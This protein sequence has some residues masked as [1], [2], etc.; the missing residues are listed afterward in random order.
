MKHIVDTYTLR[1]AKENILFIV[2]FIFFL[3]VIIFFIPFQIRNYY[4]YQEKI[5]LLEQDINQLARK[6]SIIFSINPKESNS[7]V[8]TLN[9]L[10][11]P[12]EDYFSIFS[13]LENISSKTGFRIVS[14]SIKISQKPKDKI[15]V[16]VNG[17]GT[18]DSFLKFLE[19]YQY[20]G[21]R[22]ITMDNIE[23]SPGN[24]KT[25]LALNFYTKEMKNLQSVTNLMLDKRTREK[26]KKIN[27]ETEFTSQISSLEGELGEL[28]Y[29]TKQNPFAL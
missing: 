18:P 26:I 23:F 16:K 9:S 27:Q 12:S 8:Q 2:V 19:S 28:E 22:L 29:P 25:S 21:S 15:V 1:L 3:M 10:I 24:F 14:Y 13:T 7:L 11:P 6:K 4:N 17:E 5:K 20:K